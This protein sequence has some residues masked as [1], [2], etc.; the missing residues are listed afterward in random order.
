MNTSKG[1]AKPL[2]SHIDEHIHT[3]IHTRVQP[4]CSACDARIE[5]NENGAI[6]AGVEERGKILC[7]ECTKKKRIALMSGSFDHHMREEENIDYSSEFLVQALLHGREEYEGNPT[8]EGEAIEKSPFAPSEYEEISLSPFQTNNCDLEFAI[9]DAL[10]KAAFSD[11]RSAADL[12]YNF[13]PEAYS[14]GIEGP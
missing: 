4:K 5:P 11:S 2:S 3:R 1:S 12:I 7:D 10:F 6:S 14:R 9:D 8:V 13:L